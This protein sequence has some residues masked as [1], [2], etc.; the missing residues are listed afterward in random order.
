MTVALRPSMLSTSADLIA[1][2]LEGGA[3][4][5]VL[6]DMVVVVLVVMEGVVGIEVVGVV[7]AMAVVLSVTIVGELVI[8]L[9]T[10]I[11]KVVEAEVE[12]VVWTGDMAVVAVDTVAVEGVSIVGRKGILRG[13]AITFRILW[14]WIGCSSVNWVC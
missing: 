8:W 10:V 12:A 5:V 14:M 4:V 7:E 13:I 6:A 3:G 11:D 9:G 2:G 1:R